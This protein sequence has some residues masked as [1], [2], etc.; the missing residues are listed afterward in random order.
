M[1]Q[2]TLHLVLEGQWLTQ[3]IMCDVCGL[4]QAVSGAVRVTFTKTSAVH[5]E[6]VSSSDKA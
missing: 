2:G 5:Q 1:M 6:H 3:T 4:H